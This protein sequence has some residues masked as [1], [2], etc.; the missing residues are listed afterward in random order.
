M[1]SIFI[2]LTRSDTYIS[3]MIY[4]ATA[5]K[6]THA[7]ISF[8]KNL[9]SL[10]S[11]SRKK[12][13]YPLPAGLIKENLLKGYYEKC[14]AMPCA[15]YEIKVPKKKY[16]QAKR[17]VEK[18]YH[19]EEMYRYSIIGLILCKFGFAFPRK[20]HYFCSQ[21]V[22]EILQ[23]NEI[24]DL[25]K[26]PSLMRPSDYMSVPE[27]TCL[28]EGTLDELLFEKQLALMVEEQ[29]MFSMDILAK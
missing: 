12:V 3:K 17:E 20:T 14:T 18:M 7:S 4:L 29:K 9:G 24:L 21:F 27:L 19:N 2:L 11:F 26:E 13:D 22:S 23:K 28:F 8:D 10:Y 15:L 25:P 16:H 6:Y 5:D 1:K